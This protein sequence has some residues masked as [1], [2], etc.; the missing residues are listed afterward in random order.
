[1]EAESPYLGWYW[2]KI[3][4]GHV[5]HGLRLSVMGDVVAIDVAGKWEYPT[6]NMSPADTKHLCALLETMGRLKYDTL[7]LLAS[8]IDKAKP[9]PEGP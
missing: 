1:M 5:E 7:A 2:R 8:Y 9:F 3:D 6:C 4:T